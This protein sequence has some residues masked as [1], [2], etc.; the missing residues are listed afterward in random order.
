[1]GVVSWE[2]DEA[3]YNGAFKNNNLRLPFVE[4]KGIFFRSRLSFGWKG[5][6][7]SKCGIS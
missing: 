6:S 2:D 5:V 4:D 3:N 1:M 7:L